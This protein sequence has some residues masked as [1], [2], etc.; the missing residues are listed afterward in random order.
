MTE[1]RGCDRRAVAS[2]R[3]AFLQSVPSNPRP[4][5]CVWFGS[6]QLGRGVGFDIWLGAR[7]D[8]THANTQAQIRIKR[9]RS[10]PLNDI[11]L[12]LTATSTHYQTWR[13]CVCV[14]K[15]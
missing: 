9:I 10:E 12:K 11:Y 13:N 6:D 5:H 7:L 4:R 14:V 2:Y 15:N 1:G 3:Q 8:H